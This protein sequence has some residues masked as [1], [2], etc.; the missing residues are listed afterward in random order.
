MR[1]LAPILT[2][3]FLQV[4]MAASLPV[5]FEPGIKPG[6]FIAR[7]GTGAVLVSSTGV[8]FDRDVELRMQGARMVLGQAERLLPGT[9]NYFMGSD[10][11]QWRQ[12]VPHYAGVRFRGVYPGID[13]V[14][15]GHEG[16]LE[17]DF[18][19]APH[20]DLSRIRL[21]FKGHVEQTK[22]G[23]LRIRGPLPYGRGSE[24]T[25]KRPRVFQGSRELAARYHVHQN[26][27]SIEIDGRDPNQALVIDPVIESSTY[28]GGGSYEAAR[29]IKLD[30]QGNVYLAGQ[31]PSPGVFSGPFPSTN[32]PGVDVALIKFNPQSN[33]IAYYVFLGGDL[34][35]IANG[36]AL[37]ASG[38]AYV[39]G[40]TRSANFPVINGFQMSP[41]GGTFPDAFVAKVSPDG[42]SIV[43]A[44]YLGGSGSDEAFAIAVDATGAAYV[45]GTTGSRNFPV[46]TGAYQSTFGGSILIQ[47]ATGFLAVIAPAG[48]KIT[49][50]TLLGGSRQ[51]QV[52]ALTLDAGNNIY[53]AGN[54]SSPD[55]PIRGGVQTSLPGLVAG[56]VSKL[57]SDLSQLI[58]STYVGGHSTTSV[59]AITVDAQG[60]AIAAGYT[61]SID[62][63]VRSAPQSKYGGGDRD[64]F[65][66][67]LTAQ[68]N[69]YLFATYLG[70]S[71]VDTINDVT[72]EA[73]GLLTV[74]GGTASADFP[75]RSGFASFQGRAPNQDAFVAKFLLPTNSLVFSTLLGGLADDQA[76][77]VQVD[78][79][80]ATYVAG[81]TAS[82]DFPVKGD[83]YQSQFGGG[84]GDMF[85]VK[86]SAD[87]SLI[88]T[89]PTLSVSPTV[90]NFVAAQGAGAPPV[91]AQ[92]AVNGAVPFTVD[93]SGGS[94]LTANP[95]R[96]DAPATINVFTN[97]AG[98]A[99]GVYT[100]AIRV[101]PSNGS[102]P[103]VI[104]VTLTVA[105]AA[106]VL[107]TINPARVPTG[108]PDTEFTLTG[109]GF[110]GNS[111]VQVFLDDGSLAQT[112]TPTVA[113]ESSLRCTI[114][115]SL[116]FRDTLLQLRVKDSGS[117]TVSNTIAVQVGD[118][119]PTIATVAS[120]ASGGGDAIAPGE[121]LTITGSTLGPA[122]PLGVL[123]GDGAIASTAIGGVRVL[124]DGIAAPLLSVVDH[125]VVAVTPWSLSN[126]QTTQLVIEYLGVRS[127][128][129]MV[130][131][132]TAAPAIFTADGSGSGQGLIFNES[133]LTNA[134]FLPAAKGSA[135]SLYFTGAGVMSPAGS[136]GKISGTVGNGPVLAVSVTIDGIP[137]D[138]VS[139]G[140][141]LGE[142][143]GMVQASVRIAAG[144]R[145][146]TAVPIQ[147]T[148]G[149]VTSQPGVVLAVQ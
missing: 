133:G 100:G 97:Q 12:G 83:A 149:G 60:S 74:A 86:L 59:N 119:F 30:G 29:A 135:I 25:Q 111:L 112:L 134:A 126:R 35:D 120:A 43:Y 46:Q 87:P 136:D 84:G 9:S 11:G 131:V 21:V 71:D 34:D 64:G 121:Y 139:I 62:F 19:A 142:I 72:L 24:A 85:L 90:L 8:R 44:S 145:S 51:E 50:S 55:F 49:S 52:R 75:Q 110:T 88:G 3:L 146:G 10:R 77:G 23:D 1:V 123:I 118:R 129:V 48:N 47:S 93:W 130:P 53:A 76:Y 107:R 98:L 115:K 2:T 141:A 70:G 17:Y 105:N 132:T 108:S 42:K 116:L 28:F 18:V 6:E 41:G 81:V 14:Y 73:N 4:A 147:V 96:A 122:L 39:T 68:G 15:Y 78:S 91:A 58:Y 94:W 113:G 101:I 40:S 5:V 7:V 67:R 69:D 27:V 37:D 104:T 106:P 124:F 20:A 66:A 32:N 109:S 125:R 56:F 127:N 82:S 16:K 102:T 13:V 31:A 114:G 103:V 148:V 128:A 33:T 26:Q 92:V 137:C 80:G 22:E 143:S 57:S 117:P 140:N 89:V 79:T 99:V 63:P 61:S 138:L 54:T 45:G 36:L 95:V 144:V 38:A 65:I